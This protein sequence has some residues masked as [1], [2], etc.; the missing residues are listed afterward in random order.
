MNGILKHAEKTSDLVLEFP[1]LDKDSLS[2]RVYSDSSNA[3]NPDGTSQLGYIIF[4]ADKEN[5]CF[6]LYWSSRKAKRVIRSV[7]ASETLAFSDAFHTLSPK[8]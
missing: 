3:N 1:T 7:L 6:P 5:K 2:L 8:T 4:F